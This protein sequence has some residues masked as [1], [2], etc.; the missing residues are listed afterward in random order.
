MS[1]VFNIILALIIL[2][3]I[4]I[5]H[6][7]G[8]FIFA[9]INGVTVNEFSLGMGPKLLSK[10]IKGTDF[11]LRLLP[12]GGACM[13]QGEDSGEKTP[14]SFAS[15]NVWQRISIV[16]AGPMF[17]F[18]LAFI[19]AVIIVIFGGYD[20]AYVNYVQEDSQAEAAGLREDDLIKSINGEKI[21]IGRD[22]M[23]Y[24][25]MNELTEEP[26]ELV[27]ERDG[28]EIELSVPTEEV[29]QYFIGISYTADDEPATVTVTDNYPAQNAGMI[30]G[31]II[32]AVNGTEVSSG[33]ELQDYFQNNPLDGSPV[34]VTFK[35]SSKSHEI[36][37]T[38]EW[39]TLYSLN[40]SY[41]TFRYETPAS[42]VLKYSLTEVRFWISS[43][44][45]SL[46]Y[47][48][49]GKAHREDVGSAVR[50]VSE[51]SNSVE[52]SK[53][54]GAKYVFLNLVYWAI[55]I[56]A[57]LGVMNL[58]PIPALDGGRLLFMLIEVVRGKPIS[59]EKEGIV[60]FVGFIILMLLMV[61]LFYNDIV[62]LLR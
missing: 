51:I 28:K 1:T 29:T 49:S 45:D 37:I 26:L 22:A 42:K 12:I 32:T 56:S 23:L 55:V 8:H 57:N 2:S 30:T 36:T 17:N 13:M 4:V 48:I 40:F 15:K 39:N 59:P 41:N 47:L 3:V 33:N 14:G 6:E 54:Y 61:F 21:V 19:L 58:L 27:V 24:F 18:I 10:K 31:D 25:M 53:E 62:Y 35:H 44:V 34:T 38:P 43:T 20:P 46:K 52:D 50:V 9:R 60:H 7:F 5:I 11:T 16:F